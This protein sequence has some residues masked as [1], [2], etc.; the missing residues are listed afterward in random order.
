MKKCIP[1]PIFAFSKLSICYILH[2]SAIPENVVTRIHVKLEPTQYGGYLVSATS[3][4]KLL[5]FL[6]IIVTKFVVDSIIAI[7]LLLLYIPSVYKELDNEAR[8]NVFCE[9]SMTTKSFYTLQRPRNTPNRLKGAHRLTTGGRAVLLPFYV[10]ENNV[11]ENICFMEFQSVFWG[12]VHTK[13]FM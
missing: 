1:V 4:R 8:Q 6:A 9:H 7:L 12:K 11:W 2:L 3:R 5:L 13:L 10:F